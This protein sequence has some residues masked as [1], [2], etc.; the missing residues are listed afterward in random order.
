[1]PRLN[2]GWNCLLLSRGIKP[3]EVLTNPVTTPLLPTRTIQSSVGTKTE[4]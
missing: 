4:V 3:Q 1:M 2:Y